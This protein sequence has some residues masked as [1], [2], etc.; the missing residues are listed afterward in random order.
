ML[1]RRH[2]A[3]TAK[4][5]GWRLMLDEL[6]AYRK[7]RDKTTV[8][9]NFAQ[10]EAERKQFEAQKKSFSDRHKTIDGNPQDAAEIELD[11]GL[12]PNER[13]LKSELK[14]EKEAKNAKD[15]ML[16]EAAHILADEVGLIKTDTKLAAQVLPYKGV[17]GVTD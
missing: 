12:Q 4:S 17:A 13:S 16:D 6:A 15:V 7:N 2:D 14:E 8:S 9:L 1:E 10:R 3:R 11:D 5:A